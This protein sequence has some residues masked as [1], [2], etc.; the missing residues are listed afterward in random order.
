MAAATPAKNTP[1]R[2]ASARS[3]KAKPAPVV[4]PA[5][6][7]TKAAEEPTAQTPS[8]AVEDRLDQAELRAELL[9]GMPDLRPAHR[10]RIR[11]RNNFHN[12][13]LEAVKTGAFDREN[14]DYDLTNAADIEDFQKLQEFVVSIDE[15][16]ES[17]ADDPEAYSD[18][19]EGKDEETFMALYVEY[20]NA[21]GESRGSAS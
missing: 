6:V 12:L 9:D 4:E 18:W 21:L 16:A 3:T 5:E 1:A 14:L 20:R 11:H 2:P 7:D 15:W 17:I 10:F 13:T 8:E 19:S